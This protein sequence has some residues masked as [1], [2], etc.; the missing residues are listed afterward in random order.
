MELVRQIVDERLNLLGTVAVDASAS[1]V[2]S[3]AS[4]L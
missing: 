1:I 3:P 2:A 4:A